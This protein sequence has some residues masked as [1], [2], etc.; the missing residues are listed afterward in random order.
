MRNFSLFILVLLSLFS[1][2]QHNR[3]FKS[4]PLIDASTPVWAKM[5]YAPN[6]NVYAV[7]EAFREYH[8]QHEDEITVHTVNYQFWRKQVEPFVQPDGSI[9]IPAVSTTMAEDAAWQNYV[10][11]HTDASRGSNVWSSIGP[12]D[13]KGSSTGD[14]YVSWQA[15]V[16]C[17][18]VFKANGNILYCGSEAGGIYKTTDKGLNWVPVSL[19]YTFQ[20]V[21]AI[22][23]HPTNSSIVYAGDGQHIYKTTDGGQ[24]WATVYSA[25]S[26]GVNDISINPSNTSVVLAACDAGLYYSDDAG[27]TWV[28]T[29]NYTCWDLEIKPGVDSVVYLLRT[30]PT[31][32]RCEFYR[33]TDFGSTFAL[34][35][36]GWY[37]STDAN[38]ND[39]GARMT[40]TP[41]DPN[42]IYCVLI[43]N[44]K[45]ND[46]DFIG[47]YRSNDGG[48]H[49]ANA[50]GQD[51]GPYTSNHPNLATYQDTT[52]FDQGY[53]NLS[54]AASHTNA[55][56]LLVGFLSLWKSTDGGTTYEKIGGY[57]GSLDWVH[58]DQQD[59]KALGN[60]VWLSNDGGVAYSSDFFQ[61][62]ESRKNGIIASEYWG[63]GQGWND[64]IVVGGRY[65]NGNS[66]Y[67]QDTYPTGDH[68]R[69]GGAEAS[70]GYVN[71]G[72][73]LCY[74]SDICTIKLPDDFNDDAQCAGNLE[75]YPNESYYDTRSGEVEFHPY[76]Y[77]YI[78]VSKEDKIYFSKNGG[79]SFDV[80]YEFGTDPADE[81]YAMEISR[82]NPLV[83]YAVQQLTNTTSTVWKTTDGGAN[84]TALTVP[85]GP[86]NRVI[87]GLALDAQDE[88]I[89]W[90]SA[91]RAT[92]D[93]NKVWQSVNGGTSW[94]NITSTTLATHKARNLVVQ[95]GT[96]GLVYMATDKGVFYRDNSMSDWQLYNSGL[97]AFAASNIMHPFYKKS[98][99]RLATYGY[100]IWEAP[101]AQASAPIAQPT[102]DKLE[103]FCDRDTFYFEDYSILNQSNA[104]WQWSFTPTPL[105]VSSTTVRNPK[106]VFGN[107][108]TYS[109]SLTINDG[110]A[111]SS[112]TLN[113]VI[114]VHPS[115]C[116]LDTVP[117][118]ALNLFNDDSY[119]ETLPISA[120]G[121]TNHFTVTA[122]IKPNGIQN[123]YSGIAFTPAGNASGLDFKQN[124]RLGY[125][126]NGQSGTWTWSNGPFVNDGEWNFVAMVITPDSATIY[127][128]GV[129]STRIATHNAVDMNEAGFRIGRDR[130]WQDRTFHGV[131]DEVAFYNRALSQNEIRELRHLTRSAITD[132]SLIAYY[133]FNEDSGT[134]LDRVGNAHAVY[135][136]SAERI[137]STAPVGG[138]VSVR[139]YIAGAQVQNFSTV[140]ISTDF[141]SASTS[142]LGEVVFTRL[143]VPPDVKPD[144]ALTPDHS[145]YIMNDY[146]ISN[147]IMLFDS[148][149]FSNIFIGN[150]YAGTTGNFALYQRTENGEGATWDLKESAD[151]LVTGLNG[152]VTFSSNTNLNSM[153]QF[154]IGHDYIYSSAQKLTPENPFRVFPNPLSP[155][156][157]LRILSANNDSYTFT[158]YDLLGQVLLSTTLKGSTS[159][160]LP[161][162]ESGNYIYEIVQSSHSTTG[163]LTILK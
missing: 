46:K 89:L 13:T 1:K 90:I 142:P 43:G 70:T 85:T 80:L 66:G 136:D 138:G 45:A 145:Y 30:N 161:T 76:C 44:S 62:H 144:T 5:M 68:L 69:L 52:G 101:F 124:N 17:L 33:S 83:M 77:N 86:S 122:W 149:V 3:F 93:G 34:K 88:N 91:G 67:K 130:G 64:D 119:A 78:Y 98:K 120:L 24:T 74:F 108:G 73:N 6:P 20:T 18:D 137:V 72:N 113:N 57:G 8:E 131:I 92:N 159:L 41:A 146:G 106:V 63:F 37:N 12:Y 50:Y 27:A 75:E 157:A 132:P 114:T 118:L 111:S 39:I 123:E 141:F 158:V 60:D 59:M 51:G 147:G 121:T 71:P 87:T 126:W 31:A 54:I 103:S 139:A 21:D 84:W 104:T 82:S 36:T 47:I 55:D 127:S 49:W 10:A 95:Q 26:L 129:G 151:R 153:S 105:Y 61:S 156:Q 143:N 14:P 7:D 115:Q 163:R 48:D 133:Q 15:N 140:G 100:G 2:A 42:R 9:V 97:P 107:S 155:K 79:A 160:T 109:V 16:Y 116:K 110:T 65:H 28:K 32:K 56:D 4:Q 94:N 112:K 150:Q 148:L 19:G 53:Y 96:N 134:I 99:L 102:V 135:T 81:V 40:V 23:I 22:K 117:G 125:H 154:A 29:L 11:A 38:R 128:N 25:S 162:V 58:P 35:D 152:S